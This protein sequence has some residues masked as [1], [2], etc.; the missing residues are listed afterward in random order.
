MDKSKGR[1][2]DFLIL[3]AVLL[4]AL[5]FLF[6]NLGDIPFW[7]DE[8][9]TAVIASNTLS[10]GIPTAWDGKNL[11][12]SLNS[13]DFNDDLIWTWHPWSQFYITA[14][15]FFILGKNTFA[16]RLPFALAGLISVMLTYLITARMTGDR[17]TGTLAAFFLTINLQFILFCRQCRYYG[18]LPLF[19]L[20]SA[21]SL[22]FIDKRKGFY[23]FII[24]SA[25]LFHSNYASFPFVMAGAFAY[26]IF[27][28]DWDKISKYLLSLIPIALLTVP[29]F[30][31]SGAYMRMSEFTPADRL[32]NYI[33]QLQ[34]MLYLVNEYMFPLIVLMPLLYL[35]FKKNREG[36][37]LAVLCLCFAMPVTFLLP[38]VSYTQFIIGIRYAAGCFPFMSILGAV[39]VMLI[40]RKNLSAGLLFLSI[41][42]FTNILAWVPSYAF[43]QTKNEMG[44][45]SALPL[46]AELKSALTSKKIYKEFYYELTHHYKSPIEGISDFLNE[47]SSVDDIVLTN[48]ERDPLIF[49]THRKMAYML[50]NENIFRESIPAPAYSAKLNTILPDYIFSNERIDWLIERSNY[51][52]RLYKLESLQKNLESKGQIEKVFYLSYP[53]IPWSNRADLRYH[54]FR[55]AENFPPI[56]IYKIKRK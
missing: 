35:F 3:F 32:N 53:D 10:Q 37:N 14:L 20:L 16:G 49:Y 41:F 8:G 36:R 31:Y 17:K 23:I 12:S 15:S 19:T 42:L 9:E 27:L 24:S 26:L 11:V 33:L 47:N 51:P 7:Q 29:W 30:I 45:Y 44:K 54:K 39:S 28:R 40:I 38:Y 2:P 1:L 5:F 21:Y 48:Y 56:K 55:T 22:A 6:A 25:L 4:L 43:R 52:E 50:S 13:Y 34:D 18:L 46:S